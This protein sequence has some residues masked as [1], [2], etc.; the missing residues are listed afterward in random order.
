[1]NTIAIF[2]NLIE[3][4][5][6]VSAEASSMVTVYSFKVWDIKNDKYEYPTHKRPLKR[7]SAI[8]G[9]VIEGSEEEVSEADLDD[10]Q[11]YVPKPKA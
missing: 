10:Q 3:L 4:F 7:I 8:K 9:E 6:I 1:M 5:A 2:A 11:R